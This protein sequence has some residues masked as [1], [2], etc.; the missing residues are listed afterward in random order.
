M[1]RASLQRK[2]QEAQQVQNVALTLQGVTNHNDQ[3]RREIQEK[4]QLIFQLG[5]KDVNQVGYKSI[6]INNV[7]IQS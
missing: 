2:I 4:I 1:L 6:A 3:M 7:A 5:I